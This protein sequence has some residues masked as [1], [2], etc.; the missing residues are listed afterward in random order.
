MPVDFSSFFAE[1][2]AKSS[3]S[4]SKSSQSESMKVK[5]N[6]SKKK[7]DNESKVSGAKPV[8]SFDINHKKSKDALTFSMPKQDLDEESL[9]KEIAHVWKVLNVQEKKR[10]KYRQEHPNEEEQENEENEEDYLDPTEVEYEDNK[11]VVNIEGQF[12]ELDIKNAFEERV[13]GDIKSVLILRNKKGFQAEKE[14]EHPKTTAFIEFYK[15]SFCKK[16]LELNGGK[17]NDSKV[18]VS[19]VRKKF[20]NVKPGIL[21]IYFICFL[22]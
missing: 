1:S 7:S 5:Q 8:E 20:A 2:K 12:N 3:K 10:E 21:F 9:K 14:R 17:I 16:A 22:L 15:K 13:G 19:L 4:T 11:V 6:V 18:G